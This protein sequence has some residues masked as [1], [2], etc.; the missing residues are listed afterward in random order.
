MTQCTCLLAFSM[1]LREPGMLGPSQRSQRS[2][3]IQPSL[4]S[5][6]GWIADEWEVIDKVLN[7]REAKTREPLVGEEALERQDHTLLREELR[8]RHCIDP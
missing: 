8:R 6:P 7:Q 4:G 3:P 1:A 2:I 5:S